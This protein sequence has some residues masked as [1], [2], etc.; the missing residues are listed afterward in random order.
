MEASALTKVTPALKN[1][2]K[3]LPMPYD[4]LRNFP[5]P[6]HL[7]PIRLHALLEPVGDSPQLAVE[8]TSHYERDMHGANLE[9]SHML[10]AVVADDN[11]EFMPQLDESG[12]GV[13]SFSVPVADKKGCSKDFSPSVS[14]H[15]YI[16]A[17]WGNGSFYTY[18]LAEKVWMALGLTPRC[19]GNDDQRLIYDDLSLPEFGVVEGEISNE[20]YWSSS[21]NVRWAMS[22][23]YLRKYLWMR[24]AYGV[25]AF[26]Y[27]SILQDGPELRGLMNGQPHVEIM[28]EG[29]WYQLDI[30]EH[31]HGL[32][33]QV[34][35]TVKA[36]SPELCP[37][38]SAN[39]VSWPDLAGPMTYAR[40]NALIQPMHVFLNDKFLQR[41]EQ[42]SFYDTTP[43]NV[44]GSWHCSPSYRGQWS[45][46]DC[47]RVGRNL[48]R[49]P[50]RELYKAKP[51]R[52]ILHAHAFAMAKAEVAH[53]ELQVEH[54]VSKTRR[55][56]EQLLDL[57]D[58]F[59]ELARIMGIQK[60]AIDIVGFSRAEIL[61]N[62]WMSY[63]LLSRLAQVASLDMTQQ[64]FLSRCKSL[65]EIWQRIPDGF[66]KALFANAVVKHG[67]PSPKPATA[68]VSG[69]RPICGPASG[70]TP[71]SLR[72][73][74]WP[75][76]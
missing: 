38:Q 4:Y 66:L 74:E 20:Y 16:V 37:E 28:T 34:W 36:V 59:S 51:D 72:D 15:D 30:R 19:V 3:L 69:H 32:L 5:I 23:E 75:R 21:R 43:T 57:G 11:S 22:N 8:V 65:H 62:G 50:I 44:Y 48:I 2:R 41:Y 45:F 49:V 76:H 1:E 24:N 31:K 17:S 73:S 9:Y 53:Y 33:L 56:L 27:E 47:I 63:P 60:S 18:N 61:A 6:E 54:I 29:G 26:H 46:T 13:V 71:G 14:G 55:L 39:G 35:A 67:Y 7:L 52:E 70:T 68:L 58:N 42:N 25:R 40:V 64:A 12:D 10:M